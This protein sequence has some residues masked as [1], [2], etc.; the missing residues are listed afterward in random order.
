M[1][2]EGLLKEF[3]LLKD[4][5]ASFKKAI[6]NQ[7]NLVNEI[8]NKVENF[9][10]IAHDQSSEIN[11]LSNQISSLTPI[12]TAFSKMRIDMNKQIVES[13]KRIMLEVKMQD[14][15]R[16]KEMH[17]IGESIEKLKKDLDEGI[18]KKIKGFLDENARLV[19]RFKEIDR[20]VE[21]KISETEEL[22]GNWDL[23]QQEVRQHKKMVD[24]HITDFDVLKT[25][26]DD[27]RLK[28]D[29]L[30]NDE[31]AENKRINELIASETERR[32]A[33]VSL[34]D[35]QTI[36]RN[37]QEKT[38]AEWQAQFESTMSRINSLLPELQNQQFE[39]N[40][41]KESFGQIIDR[42]ERR[43]NE[44]TEMYRL[45]DEKFRKEW[46]TYKADFEKRLANFSLTFEDRQGRYSEQHKQLHDR[47]LVIEDRTNDIQEALLVMSREIQKGIHSLMNM[48]NNWIDAFSMI[49]PEK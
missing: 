2:N 12:D 32:S 44:L 46:D 25:R 3:E 22:K 48:V 35:Q 21:E 40:K 26:V 7:N 20:R 28:M 19:Q 42:F 30:I 41:T 6:T 29:N 37:N 47:I 36:I 45:M 5:M 33:F 11:R 16:D 39:M 4:Q 31:N 23:L 17:S 38:W 8:N 43:A 1:E 34:I 9:L 49:K 15:I 18:D 13:E 27:L 24:S 14:N 10:E